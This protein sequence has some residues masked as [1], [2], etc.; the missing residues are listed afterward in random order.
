[1]KTF[2]RW[3][4]I[5]AFPY[6]YLHLYLLYGFLLSLVIHSLP[7][8]NN[9]GYIMSLTSYFIYMLFLIVSMVLLWKYL[10]KIKLNMLALVSI[11]WFIAQIA[12]FSGLFFGPRLGWLDSRRSL[13]QYNDNHWYF[14]GRFTP[15]YPFQPVGMGLVGNE[16]KV[17][18]GYFSTGKTYSQNS[19]TGKND[20]Y[21][22]SYL[23]PYWAILHMVVFSV[24]HAAFFLIIFNK[25]SHRKFITIN[26][27]I[28]DWV[29][30]K[31]FVTRL[32]AEVAKGLLESSGIL[33]RISSDDAGGSYPF[34]LQ[35]SSSGTKLLV[36][37]KNEVKAR[38]LFGVSIPPSR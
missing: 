11:F 32:E 14:L 34:P 24:L 30:I 28:S 17:P 9:S 31:T 21:L 2:F 18:V 13:S 19:R 15:L 38:E 35:P 4:A 12:L 29:C 20:K 33:S 25:K 23:V 7:L 1:M 16:F 37:K 26:Y 36:E 22:S 8:V 6:I 5:L 3:F 27:P 10:A